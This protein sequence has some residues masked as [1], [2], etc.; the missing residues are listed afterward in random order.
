MNTKFQLEY[1]RAT[2]ALAAGAEKQLALFPPFVCFGDELVMDWYYA[3]EH[4][5]QSTAAVFTPEQIALVQELDRIIHCY[6]GKTDDPL[7]VTAEALRADPRWEQIR[8]AARELIVAMRWPLLEPWPA[9]ATYVPARV[10]GSMKQR[11]W[12]IWKSRG[13]GPRF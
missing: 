5:E 6:G 8:A 10:G 13:G 4:L 3:R 1:Q 9:N 2:Y 12:E 7:F 11:W